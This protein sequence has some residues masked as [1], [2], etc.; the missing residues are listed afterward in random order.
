MHSI[1]LDNFSLIFTI[2]GDTSVACEHLVPQ[3]KIDGSGYY[4]SIKCEVIIR[5]GYTEFKAQ[6]EWDENVCLLSSC[7]SSIAKIHSPGEKE[8]KPC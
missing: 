4:W 3:R 1:G 2:H 5:F 7:E 8:A 6:I